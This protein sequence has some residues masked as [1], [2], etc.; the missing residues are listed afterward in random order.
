MEKT[1]DK[2]TRKF[3]LEILVLVL[4]FL[5][6]YIVKEYLSEL[7]GTVFIAAG[8]LYLSYLWLRDILNPHGDK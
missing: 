5:I 3:L 8:T 2:Q 7:I 6:G 1:T 4:L